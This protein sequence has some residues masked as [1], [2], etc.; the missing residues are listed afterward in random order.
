[1]KKIDKK[2]SFEPRRYPSYDEIQSLDRKAV[3]ASA[4]AKVRKA[5][6]KH[7]SVY[8]RSFGAKIYINGELTQKDAGG[9]KAMFMFFAKAL[10]DGPGVHHVVVEEHSESRV[11]MELLPSGMLLVKGSLER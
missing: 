8:Q 5:F 4:V 9:T 6:P 3:V 1:M 10:F 2:L 7:P 11:V